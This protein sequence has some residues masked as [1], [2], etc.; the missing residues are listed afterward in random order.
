MVYP[1]PAPDFALSSI[2]ISKGQ[3]LKLQSNSIALFLVFSGSG[4][5]AE[6]ER[7]GFKRNKGEA[8]VSFDGAAS[9]VKAMEDMVIYQ[10]SVP[11]M[12]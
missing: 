4:E 9:S 1:T 7:K 5:V 6:D 8:W 2:K 11:G 10:A 12:N 3:S